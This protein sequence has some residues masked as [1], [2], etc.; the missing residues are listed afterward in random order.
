MYSSVRIKRLF[1]SNY[2]NHKNLKINIEK[3]IVLLFGGNGSGK[4]NILEAI[5]LVSSSNGFRNAKLP[6]IIRKSGGLIL[7]NFGINIEISEKKMSN[8]IG[9]GLE[10]T[11]DKLKKIL[12]LDGKKTNKKNFNDKLKVFWV[13]PSMINLF[14]GPASDRRNFLD[15]MISSYDGL[16]QKTLI[17][18][19]K[20][21][22]ERIRILKMFDLTNA[23][24]DW[25]FSIEKKIVSLGIII[26]DKRR[27][28]LDKINNY[29]I[30]MNSK[31]PTINVILT[32]QID[33][34]LKSIPAVNVEENFLKK[35]KENRKID[36][37][38]GRTNY[39]INRSDMKVLNQEK[40]E[41]S[42]NCSTGEQKVLLL[43]I[44][45]LF[46]QILKEKNS[47]KIIWLLD[48]IFAHLDRKYIN[49]ILEE[50]VNLNIQTWITNVNDQCIEKKSEYFDNILFLN[51]KDIKV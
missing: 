19:K 10:K 8:K 51:I 45:F 29:S 40:S 4:T 23:N 13:L 46:L 39:G 22:R 1:L 18:H 32:G 27:I 47:F 42:E 41:F 44:I 6:A 43:T 21:Q 14:L 37:L 12:L 49:I 17:S 3:Q 5:S 36:S 48:D 20:F 25:L 26:S 15:S 28:F 38:T 31:V 34:E 50:L 24:K 11:S 9:I 33:K 2:R 30:K 16:Y 7:K 35:L